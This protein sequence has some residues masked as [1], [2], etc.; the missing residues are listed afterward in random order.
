MDIK[1][2]GLTT[3]IMRAAM[4]QAREGRLHI[5]GEMAKALTAPREELSRF[6]PQHAEL[7]VNPDIIRLIIG[8]GGKNIKAITAATGATVD[9]EDSGKVSIFAPTAD[10]LEKAREMVS[11][12]DQRPDLGKNYQA[13]VR[14]ILEI[15]AIVEILPNVEALV[16]VVG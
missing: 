10:A 2:T 6:A 12:Y 9:I 7:Y 8:P 16:H 5:L 14:K 11:Y 3:E 15:G 4:R 1:V 13:K